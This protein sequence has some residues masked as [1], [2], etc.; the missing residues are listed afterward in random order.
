LKV[1]FGT[2]AAGTLLAALVASSTAWA[3]TLPVHTVVTAPEGTWG[4]G[5][6][7]GTDV[8]LGVF[9]VAL[10]GLTAWLCPISH[11]WHGTHTIAAVLHVRTLP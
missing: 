11:A 7:L 10:S 3:P 9:V 4:S 2:M 6:A 5:H 8:Y 1:I